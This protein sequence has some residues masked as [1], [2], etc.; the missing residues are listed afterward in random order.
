MLSRCPLSLPGH[1]PLDACLPTRHASPAKKHANL[2]IT[3]TKGKPGNILGLDLLFI[4]SGL[5]H[6]LSDVSGVRNGWGHHIAYL[7]PP[8]QSTYQSLS[9]P[10]RARPSFNTLNGKHEDYSNYHA[11]SAWRGGALVPAPTRESGRHAA[12]VPRCHAALLAYR[13]L[14]EEGHV[15]SPSAQGNEEEDARNHRGRFVGEGSTRG[16]GR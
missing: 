15:S 12:K 13:S 3:Q 1:C 14:A 8:H 10:P 6:Q 7:S 16:G 4:L 5:T 11:R 2:P 9:S